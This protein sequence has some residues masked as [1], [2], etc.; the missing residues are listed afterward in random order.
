[1]P[2]TPG[3]RV[4][5]FLIGDRLGAG[6]MGEVYRATDT[7]LGRDVALKV[8][9][10]GFTHDPERLRR[11]EQEARAAAAVTDPHIV[12]VHDVGTHEGAPYL[13]TE[14][15]EGQSLRE[16]CG[17]PLLPA[18]VL[19]LGRQLA[20]AL[21]AAH[22]RGVVH[23]DL[24]PE[25]L[26]VTS[27]GVLKVLDFGIARLMHAPSS[28]DTETGA[29][30]G[31]VGYMAP[32][33]VRGQSA[34]HRADLFAAGCILYELS[35][36]HRAFQGATSVETGYA[37]LSSEP[38]PL[39]DAVLDAVVR[40]CLEKSLDAR[41][42]S[43][44]EL[45]AALAAVTTGAV[46]VMRSKR[47]AAPL[48]AALAVFLA[49][50]LGLG[51]WYLRAHRGVAITD[52]ATPEGKPDAQR[53]Y[54]I[55]LQ[56]LRD[57]SVPVAVRAFERAALLDP[58]M[59]A[60]HLRAAIYNED[61]GG[62]HTRRQHV[63]EA[64]HQRAQLEVRDQFLL[65]IADGHVG[66]VPRSDAARAAAREA[67]ARFP[68]DAELH[69]ALADLLVNTDAA[70]SVVEF[71]AAL[72]LDP[73]CAVCRFHKA[74]AGRILSGWEASGAEIER[75]LAI[76]PNAI[77][78]LRQ[79]AFRLA[80]KG[81]C[82][83]RLA[84][85]QRVAELEPADPEA[86]DELALALAATG[87]S[88]ASLEAVLGRVAMTTPQG[89]QRDAL[90]QYNRFRLSAL[91]GDFPA[92]EAAL[93]EL[94]RLRADDPTTAGH[95]GPASTRMLI[96]EELGDRDGALHIADEYVEKAAGWQPDG[97][98]L[99]EVYRLAVLRR[100]GR[101]TETEYRAQEDELRRAIERALGDSVSPE[102]MKR[103]LWVRLHRAFGPETPEQAEADLVGA[104]K[105]LPSFQDEAIAERLLEA[106]HVQE[107]LP[108]LRTCAAECDLRMPYLRD[109]MWWDV[110][111]H[112]RAQLLLGEALELTG[113]TAGACVP[114]ARV[115]AQW[116]NAKP[117]SV[118]LEKAQERSKA[119]GCP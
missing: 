105:G 110:F 35:S 74:R 91:F 101:I 24:K 90:E 94:D 86:Q 116:K 76:N 28:G 92:A 83:E 111:L 37:V 25:N 113:D 62:E 16:L 32:E 8:L 23:R 66:A 44:A 77:S 19:D 69:L 10:E 39:E 43:A 4:G 48:L 95:L 115:I 3:T 99:V 118:S 20:S 50:G 73:S 63:A 9:R 40:R 80:Q 100:L 33:Q 60:A 36:G 38:A 21:I 53:E 42:P 119:L 15:L 14:L 11:F 22:G 41:M 104:P 72:A 52:H 55:G 6:G 84:D 17:A 34:D 45:D 29:V 102:I 97:T 79:R 47:S 114:Y 89:P 106:G 87:A 54:R 51:G 70:A 58:S 108:G 103:E 61:E 96:H 107:A 93:L 112:V 75:C 67:I 18:K 117:R 31:T 1:M 64:Q 13:V 30:L 109:V 59:A 65:Q 81:R 49:G 71:D 56:A 68:N 46:P 27:G 26:F 88:R 7:R 57:G 98:V 82:E 2:L 78:C 85:A 12:V 5:P